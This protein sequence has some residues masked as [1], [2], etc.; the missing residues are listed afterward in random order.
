MGEIRTTV[1][2]LGELLE[3]PEFKDNTID[4]AWL[5]GLIA[6]KSVGVTVEP[7]SAVINAA[8]YRAYNFVQDAISDF[9]T[10]LEKGQ[11]STLPLRE[12]QRVPI[13]LTYEDM[14]YN[15]MVTPTGPDTFLLEIGD[16]KIEVRTRQQADG[17]L[18]V[19]YGN[20]NHQLY[21]KEEPLGLRMILD[22]QTV[23][24]PTI[25]DPS[26][27]RSD[28]TGKLVRYLVED[29][30]QVEAGQ[31]FAE[32]EAMKMLITVKAGESGML[33][34]ELQPGSII[35]QGDLLAS[36]ALKDPSKV[37]KIGNFDGSLD[38][39]KT[40]GKESTTLQAFT[41]SRAALELVIDGYPLESD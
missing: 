30:A 32:A 23:L 4:T 26:E 9:K 33:K 28:I 22:G 17:S 37:K 35:S 19:S 10:N 29:G 31:A 14:R 24:L 6:S 3:T 2:Y 13:E 16:D 11:L 18:F 20:E 39:D 5:D 36:L 21:A 8:I 41:S 7:H 25:Y 1:E 40:V 12:L 34:H 38:Y 15:F 27:L